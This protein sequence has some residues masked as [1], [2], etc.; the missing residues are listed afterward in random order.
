[1]NANKLIRERLAFAEE[2]GHTVLLRKLVLDAFLL[3]WVTDLA[4]WP[5]DPLHLNVLD[6]KK[7][8]NETSGTHSKGYLACRPVLYYTGRQSVRHNQ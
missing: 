1:M 2:D 8:R 4:A 6:A 7:S 5:A 3:F